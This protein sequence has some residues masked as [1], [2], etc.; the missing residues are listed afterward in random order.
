[1]RPD[2]TFAFQR[3]TSDADEIAKRA[4]YASTLSSFPPRPPL[5]P[6][7]PE[8]T[9]ARQIIAEYRAT[10][11]PLTPGT[12]SRS[13]ALSDA[14]TAV[15]SPTPTSHLLTPL[16][17]DNLTTRPP[18]PT[19]F[20]PIHRS[21]AA[22]PDDATSPASPSSPSSP[23]SPFSVA[24]AHAARSYASSSASSVASGAEERFRF[25][26]GSETSAGGAGPFGLFAPSPIGL[27]AHA[28]ADSATSLESMG[29]AAPHGAGVAGRALA[30]AAKL[31]AP[32]EMQR[33]QLVD[34]GPV[35]KPSEAHDDSASSVVGVDEWKECE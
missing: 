12:R 3:Y 13:R 6:R 11:S 8:L 1:V 20:G 21:E 35:P 26:S 10:H 33:F 2:T 27:G 23:M 30:A 29:G 28:R 25:G 5:R 7:T 14:E 17:M 9:P 32:R 22:P 16:D 18:S 4:V 15:G 24:A 19:A 34:D 31:R